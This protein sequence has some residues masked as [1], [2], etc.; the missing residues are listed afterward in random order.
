MPLPTHP[1]LPFSYS[2]SL[3]TPTQIR[4]PPKFTKPTLKPPLSFC[5]HRLHHTHPHLPPTTP[6]VIESPIRPLHT[7]S[8]KQLKPCI[9]FPNKQT[10]NHPPHYR[11]PHRRTI[12]LFSN[13]PF[14]LLKHKGFYHPQ[15]SQFSSQSPSQPPAWTT[16]PPSSQLPPY[17][18]RTIAHSVEPNDEPFLL[19][20]KGSKFL[21]FAGKVQN[22]N[23]VKNYLTSLRSVHPRAT[24]HCYAYRYGTRGQCSRANDDGEPSGSA[25]API[26]N[27]LLS[28]D[29]TN[30][31]VVVV[32]YY[33]GTKLGVSGLIKAYKDSTKCIIEGDVN[34]DGIQGMGGCGGVVLEEQCVDVEFKFLNMDLQNVVFSAIGRYNGEILQFDLVD[35]IWAGIEGDDGD[36]DDDDD[37]GENLSK[38]DRKKLAKLSRKEGNDG[39]GRGIDGNQDSEERDEGEM[40]IVTVIKTKIKLQFYQDLIQQIKNDTIHDIVKITVKDDSIDE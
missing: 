2:T 24:H 40:E 37:G 38:R 32:R 9:G 34:K 26:L 21:T 29:V 14:G 25:G 22:E 31:L 5:A 7:P 39:V 33:G 15:S 27:Q 28:A 23:D 16:L 36:D 20:E 13:S 12:L 17:Q 19:K 8:R 18:Y 10:L 1:H 3:P 6:Q 4:I 30:V 11:L 35:E